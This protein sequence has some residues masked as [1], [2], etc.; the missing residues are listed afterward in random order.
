MSVSNLMDILKGEVKIEI[1]YNNGDANVSV[2][3]DA[4][5]V[6]FLLSKLNQNIKNSLG[7]NYK[8]ALKQ[9]KALEKI[10]KAN[11]ESNLSVSVED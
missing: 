8:L 3:G 9:S 11:T 4:S 5:M 7:K 10:H 1:K 6:L 2:S